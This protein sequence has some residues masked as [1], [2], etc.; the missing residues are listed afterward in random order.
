M[1]TTEYGANYLKVYQPSDGK[2]TMPPAAEIGGRLRVIYDTFAASTLT[3]GSTLH[4]A[5]MPALSRLWQIV[6][7]ADDTGGAGSLAVGISGSTSLFIA[8]SIL[9]ANGKLATMWPQMLATDVTVANTTVVGGLGVGG[10]GSGVLDSSF[11]YSFSSATDI[12]GTTAA[13]SMTGDIKW[14]ITY[15]VD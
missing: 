2:P 4:M 3:T 9:G 6:V 13:A 7:T 1:A 12:I 15:S 8:A 5:K 14:M 11:G 10:T